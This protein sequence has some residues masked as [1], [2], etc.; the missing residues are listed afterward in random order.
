[1]LKCKSMDDDNRP[2]II[3][4]VLAILVSRPIYFITMNSLQAPNNSAGCKFI[5]IRYKG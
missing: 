3:A 4:L 2:K 5:N 1:M